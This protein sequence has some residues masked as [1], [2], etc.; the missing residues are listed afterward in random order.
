MDSQLYFEVLRNLL[1][2]KVIFYVSLVIMW[3][4][5]AMPGL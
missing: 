4:A 5:G 3:K 2:K 1:Q